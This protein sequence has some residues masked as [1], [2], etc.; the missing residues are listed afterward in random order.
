MKIVHLLGRGL[1]GAGVSRYAQE[2]H[3]WA[4]RSGHESFMLALDKTWTLGK[5]DKSVYADCMILTPA[6]LDGLIPEILAADLLVIH[7]FPVKKSS[8]EVVQV[9]DKLL[10]TRPRTAK[11]VHSCLDHHSNSWARNYAFDE[12][13]AQ[14][15]GLMC[16]NI[17][18]R[19]AQRA[20]ASGVSVG[21]AVLAYPFGD[22]RNWI[23][24]ENQQRRVSYVGRYAT[25]KQPD[26]MIPLR[27]CIPPE[28]D[29]EMTSFGVARVIEAAWMRC[30]ASVR[31]ME[32]RN[33]HKDWTRHVDLLGL[34]LSYKREVGLKYMRETAICADFY[35]LPVYGPGAEYAILEMV[36]QGTC[37]LTS[38][39]YLMHAPVFEHPGVISE[40]LVKS[41]V[42]DA[43]AHVRVPAAVRSSETVKIA[44]AVDECQVMSII[45]A[46]DN[47][48][49]R[50]EMRDEWFE[51]FSSL[52]R[53]EFIFPKTIEIMMSA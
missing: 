19:L 16:H 3:Q 39:Q 38:S 52:Y 14:C 29:V 44:A 28:F 7:S 8:V 37:V 23:P 36:D 42:L 17:E 20:L 32:K 4:M 31:V 2:F 35:N 50:E 43:Q 34:Y 46:L 6:E 47:P 27:D 12:G 24:C 45:E 49:W 5:L 51:H 30:H 48:Q 41:L 13:I 9:W 21:Q 53:P 10:Q 11:V 33:G 1:E 15:D 18:G 22:K 25:F 26:L 40:Y